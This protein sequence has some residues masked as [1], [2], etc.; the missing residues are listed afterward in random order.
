METPFLFDL[1]VYED[2]RGIFSP[3][4]IEFSDSWDFRLK[5]KW[6]QSNISFNPKLGT[7]RGMHFQEPFSQSKLI[8]V[9]DGEIIDFVIDLRKHSLTYGDVTSYKVNRN[10]ALYV[11]KGFAHGFLTL[12]ENTIVQYLVDDIWA[13]DC[14]HIIN[15]FSVE[16]IKN[17]VSKIIETSN[18][19]MSDKDINGQDFN[20]YIIK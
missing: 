5:K 3:I 19:I 17:E 9:I 7:F 6:I 4:P 12:S 2:N 13:K 14:E 10:S 20:K 15:P 18:V 1:L 11:P 8:N 16:K